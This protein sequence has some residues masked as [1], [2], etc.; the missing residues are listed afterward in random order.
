MYIGLLINCISY[1]YLIFKNFFHDRPSN[2][3]KT[4]SMMGVPMMIKISFVS[5][6]RDIGDQ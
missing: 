2:L 1:V 5:T 4:M 6:E 3:K